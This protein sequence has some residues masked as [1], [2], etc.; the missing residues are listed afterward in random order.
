MYNSVHA[1]RTLGFLARTL[2]CNGDR[3]S[4]RGREEESEGDSW[5]E[6]ERE[7]EGE[8]AQDYKI[9]ILPREH[10]FSL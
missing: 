4:G 2:D 5:R 8:R 3:R 6:R 1:C 10:G 9:I 7:R